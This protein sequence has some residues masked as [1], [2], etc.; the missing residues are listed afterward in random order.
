MTQRPDLM[1]AVV[2][3]HPDLDI[4][5]FRR[6]SENNNPHAVLEYGDPADPEQFKF[7]YAYSPYEHVREGGRYPA[8]LFTT[9]EADTRVPPA[10]ARKM[11]ARM[12]AATSSGFPILLLH[13]TTRGHAGSKR[14]S[15]MLE[16]MSLDWAFLAWQLGIE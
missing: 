14:F 7:I 16:D 3:W 12:Q 9:G 2:C 11:T 8:V 15:A 10:Q 6:Y 13:D 4:V 1:H 5:R